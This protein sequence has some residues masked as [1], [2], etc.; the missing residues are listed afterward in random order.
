V[1]II[2]WIISAAII[3]ALE[4]SKQ[5]IQLTKEEQK[6]LEVHG[7]AE[8]LGNIQEFLKETDK[9]NRAH[10][11]RL[12]D[13]L[14]RDEFPRIWALGED[15]FEE[16]IEVLKLKVN[17]IHED[18]ER[19]RKELDKDDIAG[20]ETVKELLNIL[21]DGKTVAVL[22][23]ANEMKHKMI[24]E[25]EASS[26]AD[27]DFGTS[28]HFVSS[29]FTTL[30]YGHSFPETPGGKFATVL[31][32]VTLLPFFVYCLTTTAYI[33]NVSLNRIFGLSE[34]YDDLEELTEK[35]T[36]NVELRRKALIQGSLILL[37]ILLVHLLVSAI[38][39]YI[40]TG[41]SFGEVLYYEF[42]NYATIGFGEM[43]PEDE[44]TVAGA[45]LKNTL[46]KIP[47]AIILL[48]LYLRLLPLIS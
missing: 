8:G 1:F 41:W 48:T 2:L 45:I 39:H 30:G 25:A 3:G 14:R 27:W 37:C 23:K 20:Q 15:D 44:I 17:L 42:T 31:M 13:L 19:V 43:L 7:M 16:H 11:Q 22:D 12:I 35:S 5:N 28:L 24:E 32:I 10:L 47:A 26:S 9:E 46:V 6:K 29:V 4:S 34:S 38:Y 40:T 36:S 21:K 33:I 18:F